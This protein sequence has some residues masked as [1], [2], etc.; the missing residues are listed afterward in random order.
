MRLWT[1]QPLAVWQI[2]ERDGVF[3]TD[4]AQSE[5]V[6]DYPEGYDWIVRRLRQHAGP[7]PEGCKLPIWAWYRWQGAARAKPDLRK[8]RHESTGEWV[9]IEVE[10]GEVDVLLSD[11]VAWY[12]CMC[13]WYLPSSEED[14]HRLEKELERKGQN[15]YRTKPL[16]D[17]AYH[18]RIEQSWDQILDLEWSCPDGS[19]VNDIKW[20][21]AVFWELRREQVRDVTHFRG[22]WR[23]KKS[24][25]G[26]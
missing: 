5:F 8:V 6:D 7:E 17:P 10:I 12:Y 14:G 22:A 19:Y 16:P 20:V 15:F 24:R 13:Y 9:R 4:P 18:A 3:H 25:T 1:I 2:L 21:Q 26:D 23:K 11:F